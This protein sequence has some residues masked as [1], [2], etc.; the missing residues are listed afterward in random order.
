MTHAAYLL[1]GYGITAAVLGGYA[2][3]LIARRRSLSRLV[4]Q[5]ASPATAGA[6]GA[7]QDGS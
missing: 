6:A 3:W 1:A 2:W 4:N 5:V 7:G